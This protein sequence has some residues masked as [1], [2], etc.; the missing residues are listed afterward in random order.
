MGIACKLLLGHFIPFGKIQVEF[1]V[2]RIMPVP[3][4]ND[5][6]LYLRFHSLQSRILH[7]A[8]FSFACLLQKICRRLKCYLPTLLLLRE[9]LFRSQIHPERF[10]LT[11]FT[12]FFRYHAVPRN[13][14]SAKL[15]S[16]SFFQTYDSNHL[17]SSLLLRVHI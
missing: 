14:S 10:P 15:H 4:E 7:K 6:F 2:R 9:Q 13:A 11:Q 8:V 3:P 12:D 5:D 16:S 1:P 17:S